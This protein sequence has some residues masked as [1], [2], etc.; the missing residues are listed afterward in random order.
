MFKRTFYFVLLL[1]CITAFFMNGARPV[2]TTNS[3][4]QV[5]SQMATA[6]SNACTVVLPDGN[7]L[8]GGGIGQ[9]GTL[10]SAEVFAPDGRFH[11]APWMM[12]ARSGHACALL[13]DGMVI[14]AGGRTSGG[15][16]TNAVELYDPKTMT[17]K[18][19]P[20]LLA[21]RAGA[22]VSVLRDKRVMIAGGDNSFGISD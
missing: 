16:I 5:L 22:T 20:S 10:A 6:R 13:P 21:A 8:I 4:A 1:L 18:P 2:P 19:G 7:L 11:D 3:W 14:V 17:W 15:A 12:D 9:N